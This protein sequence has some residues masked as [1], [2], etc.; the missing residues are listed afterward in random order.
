MKKNIILNTL[1]LS[2]LSFQPHMHG[3]ISNWLG[4]NFSNNNRYDREE[5]LDLL[6]QGETPNPNNNTDL[7]AQPH[8][9][10]VIFDWAKD[11]F[12]FGKEENPQIKEL[13]GVWV[14]DPIPEHPKIQ[15]S[16]HIAIPK[17]GNIYHVGFHQ[18]SDGGGFDHSIPKEKNTD[19]ERKMYPIR[20]KVIANAP[21]YVKIAKDYYKKGYDDR[22]HQEDNINKQ[23]FRKEGVQNAL[24]GI[25]AIGATS[26]GIYRLINWLQGD[27]HALKKNIQHAQQAIAK[28]IYIIEK[29]GFKSESD[30]ILYTDI[31]NSQITLKNISDSILKEEIRRKTAKK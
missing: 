24:Y 21:D 10:S 9:L 7:S 5:E 6:E 3:G 20:D 31:Y 13:D 1:L 2:F 22:E 27:L 18:V 14:K 23:K 29:K 16:T 4:W 25:A 11:K 19:F 28:S 26:Y 12:G 30:E 15:L 17:N 8:M